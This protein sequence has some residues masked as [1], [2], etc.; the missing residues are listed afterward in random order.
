MLRVCYGHISTV[1]PLE[2]ITLLIVYAL[3]DLSSVCYT[4]GLVERAVD[5]ACGSILC[6]VDIANILLDGSKSRHLLDSLS[7]SQF[8]CVRFSPYFSHATK[9]E[10]R[11][12]D[13]NR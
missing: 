13:V 11:V 8:C 3:F 2:F 4:R 10:Y 1:I 6:I 12:W 9:L 5:R 7:R